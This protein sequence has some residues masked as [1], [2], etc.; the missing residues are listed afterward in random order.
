MPGKKK[1]F[2]SGIGV[3]KNPVIGGIELSSDPMTAV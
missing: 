3:R 2:S 1:Q